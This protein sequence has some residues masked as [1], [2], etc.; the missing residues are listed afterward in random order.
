MQLI[1][2]QQN[3]GYDASLAPMRP[4][5]C[6]SRCTIRYIFPYTEEALDKC[7]Q[8]PSDTNLINK[9]T[10]YDNPQAKYPYHHPLTKAK[11]QKRWGH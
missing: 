1:G 6:K 11:F 9:L 3:Q 7:S 5:G 2:L 8:V 4:L 10:K